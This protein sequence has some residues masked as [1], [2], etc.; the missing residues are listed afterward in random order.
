MLPKTEG[1]IKDSNELVLF[2]FDNLDEYIQSERF[3]KIKM[4]QLWPDEFE[5][6]KKDLTDRGLNLLYGKSMHVILDIQPSF[7]SLEGK[8]YSKLRRYRNMYTTKFPLEV[9]EE[10]NSIEEIYEFIKLWKVVRKDAHFQ[11]VTGYDINFINN[12]YDKIRDKLIALYFYYE[13]NMIGFTIIEEVNKT[14]YNLLFRKTDTRFI[15]SSLYVD[16]YSFK[17]IYDKIGVPFHFNM[18]G[19]IGSKKLRMYKEQSFNIPFFDL[20]TYDIKILQECEEK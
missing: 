7:F 19:D 4:F 11:F 16:Y 18:G 3:K 6:W 9:K 13:G 15:N 8:E 12:Y 10:P 1:F 2:K 17:Y 20:I 5:I 14:F